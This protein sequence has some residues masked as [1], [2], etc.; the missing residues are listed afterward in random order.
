MLDGG[1]HCGAIRYR[2]DEGAA[3]N[4]ALCHCA[5]CRHCAGAPVV[6][7]MQVPESALELTKG[8]PAVYTSS[9]NG[10]RAFCAVCGTGL[11]YRNA[12]MLP[13]IV[14]IQS[15]TF[16]DGQATVPAPGAHI[17]VADR[18]G[19][20]AGTESLPEFARYPGMD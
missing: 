18:L 16:D 8:E 20:M 9:E 6:G 2:V 14:D 17:Q 4:H 1:C 7:W 15:A 5:D 3:D 11:F 12:V 19:W 13:G 10:R